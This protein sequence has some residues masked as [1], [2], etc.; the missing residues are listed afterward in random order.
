MFASD[1]Y[2]VM[3]VSGVSALCIKLETPITDDLVGS[4]I[5]TSLTNKCHEDNNGVALSA[6]DVH[7]F[8][9]LSMGMPVSLR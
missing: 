4:P 5:D 1:V 6:R 3:L 2:K 9:L 7:A 8:Y